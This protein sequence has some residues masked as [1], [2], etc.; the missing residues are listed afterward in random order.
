MTDLTAITDDQI[1]DGIEVMAEWLVRGHT[2]KSAALQAALKICPT[3]RGTW[4]PYAARVTR[5]G[6]LYRALLAGYHD[7]HQDCEV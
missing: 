3:N 1:Q 7:A 2:P 6:N 5:Q 4:R